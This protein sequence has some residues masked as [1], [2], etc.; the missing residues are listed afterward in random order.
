MSKFRAWIVIRYSGKR[1][2]VKLGILQ[3]GIIYRAVQLHTGVHHITKNVTL[4]RKFMPILSEEKMIVFVS[5]GTYFGNDMRARP[6]PPPH[7]PT[8]SGVSSL[9]LVDAPQ[10]SSK[11]YRLANCF[12]P[13]AKTVQEH[14]VGLNKFMF[15]EVFLHMS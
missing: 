15:Q 8:S 11:R 5:V 14:R 2:S 1:R 9:C 4:T 3:L 12:T 7:T 6:S 10:P 13:Y